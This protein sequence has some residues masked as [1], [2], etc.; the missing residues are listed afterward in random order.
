MRQTSK[1]LPSK[2]PA[3]NGSFSSKKTDC[4]KLTGGDAPK[5]DIFAA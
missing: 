1:T 4:K 3:M 5:T 2:R